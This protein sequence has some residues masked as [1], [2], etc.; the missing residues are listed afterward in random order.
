L[1]TKVLIDGNNTR[2]NREYD[3]YFGWDDMIEKIIEILNCI[4]RNN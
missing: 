4:S 2:A 3:K 1:E